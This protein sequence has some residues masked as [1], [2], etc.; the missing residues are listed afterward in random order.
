MDKICI[1]GSGASGVHFALSLLK[2]GYEVL[3]L[4]VGFTGAP[5]PNPEDSFLQLKRRLEDPVEYFL[6]RDFESAILPDYSSEYYGLPPSKN[7]VLL[8]PGGFG[9]Q[10]SGF[11]PLF[12]FAMGG[13]AEIW[14]GGSYP[15]NDEELKGFPFGY[16]EIGPWYDEVAGRIGISGERDDLERF[17]PYH[18]NILEPLAMDRQSTML[19]EKYRKRKSYF[20]GKHQCYMGRSRVA[21]LSR[22]KGERKECTYTGRCLWGCPKGSLY[23]PSLTVKEC[24]GFKNFTYLSGRYVEYLKFGRNKEILGVTTRNIR[25]GGVEEYRAD[26][27]ALAAGTLSSSRIYMESIYR[28]T[29]EIVTLPGLMDNRQILIPFV[30]TGMLGEPFDPDS[31]QYHQVVMGIEGEVPREYIHGQITTLKTAMYHPIIQG[32]PVD[33]KRAT[34]IFRILHSSLGVVNVNLSDHRRGDSFLTLEAAPG[35]KSP[36]LAIRYV[37]PAGEGEVIKRAIR[38][39]YAILRGLGCFAPPPMTHVRPMGASVHYSGTIPMSATGMHRTD[40]FGQS[41]EYPGLY[42]VDGTTFPALPSK[43]LTFTLMANAV[44]IAEGAF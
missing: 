24:D 9:Y 5:D 32:I 33:V 15:F 2:K 6:G 17:H 16:R 39:V 3:M 31:Y 27:Y 11:A 29:G 38:K 14:T 41:W 26:R 43:N 23:T 12:S 25:D 22:D 34:S 44:R 13:L 19:L 30:N 10:A 21:T 35:E 28:A 40:E 7:H 4:D 37:P 1:I 42:F 36:R 18:G 8:S 20:N